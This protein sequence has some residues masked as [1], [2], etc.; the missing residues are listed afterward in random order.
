LVNELVP[1]L[2][3]TRLAEVRAYDP[4]L[5]N[6]SIELLHALRIEFKK[7][8]YTVEYFKEV[9]GKRAELV[10]EDLKL[11]Q[12]HLGE[13]NDAQVATQLIRE[14]IDSLETCQITLSTSGS[15]DIE[16]VVNY[17][18]TRHAERHQLMISFPLVWKAH[19]KYRRFRRNLAQAVSVL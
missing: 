12:D 2:I 6:A 11:L 3:Y 1:L 18:A 17:L 10:I 15:Q 9:L 19:F 16:G 13:L 5:E 8:R 7:L 4:F 14:F